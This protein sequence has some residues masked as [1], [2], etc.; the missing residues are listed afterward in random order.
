MLALSALGSAREKSG[1]G[2]DG[3]TDVHDRMEP[4]DDDVNGHL[5]AA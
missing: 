2:D 4:L 3:N 5:Y 1:D